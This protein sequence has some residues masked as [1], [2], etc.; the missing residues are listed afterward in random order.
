VEEEKEEKEGEEEGEGRGGDTKLGRGKRSGEGD[1]GGITKGSVGIDNEY[2]YTL[3]RCM[4]FS[5]N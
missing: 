4:T 2:D 5:N 1:L 3:Y